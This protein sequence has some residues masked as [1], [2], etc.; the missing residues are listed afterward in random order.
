[1]KRG[2]RMEGWRR[3]D[4]DI[5][6]SKVLYL[7]IYYL[8]VMDQWTLK[9]VELL[10][11]QVVSCVRAISWLSNFMQSSDSDILKVIQ[12]FGNILVNRL[13]P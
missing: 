6:K 10:I 5:G 3:G 1:M 4:P 7:V 2:R 12:L 8:P 9:R 13:R 11:F